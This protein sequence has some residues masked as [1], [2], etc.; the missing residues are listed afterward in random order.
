[1]RKLN[2]KFQVPSFKSQVVCLLLVVCGLFGLS[3]SAQ[4]VKT[5]T[6]KLNIRIGEQF[7]LKLT[8]EPAN[9][10]NL[11]IDTWF[12]IPD[13]FNHFE[14]LQRLPIDTLEVGGVKSYSQ[15]IL[16]TNYDTGLYQLPVF[17]IVMVDKQQFAT[18]PLPIKVLPVDISN[19]QDYH[20]IKEIIEVEPETDWLLYAEIGVGIVL[21]IA[22]FFFVIRYFGKKKPINSVNQKA[23]SVDDILQQI[24]ALQ[25]LIQT[26]QYKQ[27]FTQLIVITRN[28]SDNQLQILT[29]TKTTDEYMVL[30][31][32]KVGNEPTQVQ[33]FQLLRLADAVKF[34]KFQPAASECLQALQA[35]KTL[36]NTMHSFNYQPKANAV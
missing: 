4:K 21:F 34:A 14:V 16:L 28:F 13:T 20:G 35:A 27:L 24:D 7:E 26:H 12:N 29:L 8:V 22:L 6:S 5:T 17:K 32:G 9:N 36:V 19:M 15:K 33:Y 11:L 2:F 1:M 18:E 31:K 30:L 23:L 25:S 10:T 3:A